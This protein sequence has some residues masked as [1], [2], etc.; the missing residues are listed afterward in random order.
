MGR[1]KTTVKDIAKE[2]GVSPALVSFVMCNTYNSNSHYR[3]KPETARMILDAAKR[4]NYSPNTSAR[5]LKSGKYNTIGVI[6]SDISNA[7][8]SEIARVIEDEAYKHNYFVLFGSTDEDSCKFSQILKVFEN[9]GVDALIVVP[10]VGSDECIINAGSHGIPIILL[11]RKISAPFPSVTLDNTQ[12]GCDLTARLL[13]K[14]YRKIRMVSYDM[15]LSNIRDRE[16]GYSK[17]MRDHGA[18]DSD[19][20]RRIS[21]NASP[22]TVDSMIEEARKDAV[23]AFVFATNT[24]AVKGMTSIFKKGYHVPSDF[25]IACFD[26][27]DAFDIYPTDLLYARQPVVEIAKHSMQILLEAVDGATDN[28]ACRQ[29]VLSPEIID[30]NAGA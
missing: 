6:L 7:F 10:C 24:L 22:D 8:F 3:I 1:K 13:D 28:D 14:G 23:E 25:G 17:A 15:E 2:V 12:A 26:K 30:T 21:H 9:K 4:L 11:D 5:A 16:A 19:D 20:I 29:I 27:N 18:G